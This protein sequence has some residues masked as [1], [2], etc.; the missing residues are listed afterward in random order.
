MPQTGSLLIEEERAAF[1]DWLRVSIDRSGM[2]KTDIAR[3]LGADSTARINMYLNGDR[4]P[5]ARVVVSLAH[6]MGTSRVVGMVLAGYYSEVLG[7]LDYLATKSRAPQDVRE[8]AVSVALRTFP[9]VPLVNLAE[10]LAEEPLVRAIE[11]AFSNKE[12]LKIA[13]RLLHDPILRHAVEELG[14]T[15]VPPMIRREIAAKLVHE[16]ARIVD[17]ETARMYSYSQ[18]QLQGG[19]RSANVARKYNLGGTKA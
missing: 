3:A 7:V 4:I 14:K 8:E 16:W 19:L 18:Q 5:T 11:A 10:Q 2:S 12:I 1:R 6:A 15:D 17:P 9:L 13:A